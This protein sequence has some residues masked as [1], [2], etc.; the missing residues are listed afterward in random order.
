CKAFTELP[1][2][3]SKKSIQT[4][5]EMLT[6]LSR[7]VAK[8]AQHALPL[9]KLLRK[10]A[11]FEW[12]EECEQALQHLKKVL[13]EPPVLSRPDE[14]EVLYLYLAVASE[15]VS[16]TLIRE[17]TEGQKPICFTSKALQGPENRYQLIEKVA[18]ALVNAARR[19]RHYFL[20]HTIV[21]R[22]DQPIKS[23]LD[24][25]DMAGKMLKWSLKLSE[26]DIHYE[27]RKVLKA[28]VLANFVAEMTHPATPTD[29]ADK[30]TI[31]VNGA[32]S[33]T[34]AGA[35]FI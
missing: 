18:L 22:T 27:S 33:P 25:P 6:S 26:F 15:A 13:S 2:P 34:G 17:T 7:F 28:Q 5:N 21:V 23:L 12:T 29:G 4:L 1:T 35:R 16:A 14:E 24:R 3:D 8:S 10:E 20:G 31:F 32:S 11:A 30:W 19:L 9:F